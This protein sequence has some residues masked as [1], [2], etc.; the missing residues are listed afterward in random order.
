MC[1]VNLFHYMQQ[2]IGWKPVFT[3]KDE[4]VLKEVLKI[5]TKFVM[6]THEEFFTQTLDQDTQLFYLHFSTNPLGKMKEIF[7][8]TNVSVHCK[9]NLQIWSQTE[10]NLHWVF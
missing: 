2:L 5:P 10:F 9:H 8:C 6:H 7:G 1:N 4:D 3:I